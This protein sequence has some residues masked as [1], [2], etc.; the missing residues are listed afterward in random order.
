MIKLKFESGHLLQDNHNFMCL[1][2]IRSFYGYLFELLKDLAIKHC[3][4]KREKEKI[5]PKTPI[6]VEFQYNSES[7]NMDFEFTIFRT[8]LLLVN[9]AFNDFQQVENFMPSWLHSKCYHVS[10]KNCCRS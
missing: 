9:K 7:G 8:Y 10:K 5:C 6:N 3:G 2:S 1:L 4:F